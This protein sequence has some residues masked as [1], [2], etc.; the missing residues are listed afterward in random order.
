MKNL[1]LLPFL[2]LIP[3]CQNLVDNAKIAAL[4]LFSNPKPPAEATTYYIP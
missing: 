3:A 1:L 4:Y 2:L